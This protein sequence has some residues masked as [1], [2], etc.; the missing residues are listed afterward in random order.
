MYSGRMHTRI[1]TCPARTPSRAAPHFSSTCHSSVLATCPLR[2]RPKSNVTRGGQL[3]P[4][5]RHDIWSH[6][7]LWPRTPGAFDFEPRSVYSSSTRLS[8]VLAACYMPCDSPNDKAHGG[9]QLLRVSGHVVIWPCAHPNSRTSVTSALE[10]W[11]PAWTA[12]QHPPG[13]GPLFLCQGARRMPA[14]LWAD[15]QGTRRLKLLR[16]TDNSMGRGLVWR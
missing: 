6:A 10:S 4:V 5:A 11:T 16:A 15:N 7:H 9:G 2:C 3:L 1:I 14:T 13:A 8:C 12:R